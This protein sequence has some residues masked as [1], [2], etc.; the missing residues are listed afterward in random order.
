MNLRT[1]VA[2]YCVKYL[3]EL[4]QLLSTTNRKV[5]QNYLIWRFVRHRLNNLDSRFLELKQRLNF[6][7][8]GREKQPP[9]WQF[10]VTQVNTHMGMA[11]GALF[12]RRYFD[13]NSKLDTIGMTRA[14]VASFKGILEE[15]AWIDAHTK[16]YARMKID[17]MDLKIG[18]PDFVL[19]GTGE[20]NCAIFDV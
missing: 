1:P 9:R 14:L 2:V 12:V 15:S 5:I 8:Y 7:L 17:N 10:C 20:R 13:A 4:V 19:N 11:L 18:F 6:V 3:L 16:R